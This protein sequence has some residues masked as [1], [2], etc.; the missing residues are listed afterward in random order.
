MTKTKRL[1]KAV[2][3]LVRLCREPNDAVGPLVLHAVDERAD[4]KRR[5]F[6]SG[7]RSDRLLQFLDVFILWVEPAV[8][9]LNPEN[10]AAPL[11]VSRS[12][13]KCFE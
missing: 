5:Q 10:P 1:Q 3:P 9:I 8:L 4:R 6:L 11:R 2:A 13:R 12:F 7:V